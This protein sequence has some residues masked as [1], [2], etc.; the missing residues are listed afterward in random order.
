MM[1]AY[2][3]VRDA[4]AHLTEPLKVINA[5]ILLFPFDFLLSTQMMMIVGLL[6]HARDR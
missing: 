1:I 6:L 2:G 5:S 4:Y 3:L